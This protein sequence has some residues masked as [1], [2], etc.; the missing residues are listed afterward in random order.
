MRLSKPV[1]A[2]VNFVLLAGSANAATWYVATGGNDANAGSLAAPFRTITKAAS[3]AA[4]G[5]LVE[6]RGGVYNE[7]VQISSKGTASRSSAG[8]SS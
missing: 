5:D 6:V 8:S 7:V 4:A 2:V 1:V 3:R